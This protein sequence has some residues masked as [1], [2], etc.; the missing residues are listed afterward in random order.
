MRGY[1]KQDFSAINYTMISLLSS[2]VNILIVG[3]G[4]AAFIK[5]GTF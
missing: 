2:K 3:G 4:E 1:N 5:C